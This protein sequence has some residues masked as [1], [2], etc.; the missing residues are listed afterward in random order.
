MAAKAFALEVG[1]VS[2]PISIPGGHAVIEVLET[3]ASSPR[4][5]EESRSDVET[6]VARDMARK[7]ASVEA[8]AIRS[9]VQSGKTLAEAA[10]PRAVATATDF[11]Q[12]G[13]VGDL[14]VAPELNAAAFATPAGS[15]GPVTD[16]P[17]GAAVFRVTARET[18]D[19]TAD[20][21]GLADMRRRLE[22]QE[23]SAFESA[24]LLRLRESY[25]D[26]LQRNGQV[27]D[28]FATTPRG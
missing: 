20:P 28:R 11:K 8:E 13:P 2:E 26:S 24:S 22:A 23:Y 21:T 5:F 6:A 19:P 7:L 12:G 17:Q 16:T 10:A 15:L 4:T 1:S 3:R 18:V 14:G 9:A 25:K 27:L